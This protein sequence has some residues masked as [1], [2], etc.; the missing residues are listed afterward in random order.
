MLEVVERLR[1]APADLHEHTR[2]RALR[3]HVAPEVDTP[4]ACVGNERQPERLICE[5][6]L[7]ARA[8]Q[9]GLEARVADVGRAG[10]RVVVA[11]QV[12]RERRDARVAPRD[13]LADRPLLGLTLV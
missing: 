7:A 11:H 2:A 3:A 10:A 1:S 4:A 6:R 5:L 9:A 13:P 8:A 12:L